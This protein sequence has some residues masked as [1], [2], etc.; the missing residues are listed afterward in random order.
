MSKIYSNRRIRKQKETFFLLLLTL[1]IVLTAC[2]VVL[3]SNI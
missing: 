2:L 3:T 1:S